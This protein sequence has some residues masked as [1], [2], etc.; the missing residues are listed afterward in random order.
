MRQLFLN[1]R[2]R[3]STAKSSKT[4]VFK[5]IF[6]IN[7]NNLINSE[8]LPSLYKTLRMA[9]A[10]IAFQDRGRRNLKRQANVTK[11]EGIVSSR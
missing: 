8:C 10:S 2:V 1:G 5:E 6:A 9:P 3:C 7:L 11:E 4:N